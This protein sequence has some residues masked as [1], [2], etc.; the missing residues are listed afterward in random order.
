MRRLL[1]SLGHAVTT[2][3][4]AA[5]GLDRFD[6]HDVAIIDLGLPDRSGLELVPEMRRLCASTRI[7]IWTGSMQVRLLTEASAAAGADAVFDKPP[8]VQKLVA[9]VSG[10]SSDGARR[11]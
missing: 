5:E 11:G 6:A 10:A 8:D 7:A 2:A 9:W 4:S 3:G 1:A